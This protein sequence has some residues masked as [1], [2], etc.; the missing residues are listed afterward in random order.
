MS[1]SAR[2]LSRLGSLILIC[3]ALPAH[4]AQR[5]LVTLIDA[6]FAHTGERYVEQLQSTLTPAVREGTRFDV[7]VTPSKA[8]RILLGTG[9]WDLAIVSTDAL[10]EMSVPTDVLAFRIP[11]LF[12][13]MRAVLAFQTS[14]PG[15][16][17]LGDPLQRNLLGLT[18][19]NAGTDHLISRTPIRSPQ[20]LAGRKIAVAGTASADTIASL[21]ATPL[22][23]PSSAFK[24]VLGRSEVDAVA[25]S[26][27]LPSGS[28]PLSKGGFLLRNAVAAHVALVAINRARWYEVPFSVRARIDDAAITAAKRIDSAVREQEDALFARAKESGLWMGGFKDEDA[29][30]A[31]QD[32]IERQPE[33]LRKV[34]AAAYAQVRTET[35][36]R[37]NAR[38]TSA[39]SP[40]A[41]ESAT[42]YF[43]TTRDD[44]GD[45]DLAYRFGDGRT[46]VVK[47]GTVRAAPQGDPQLVGPATADSAACR[48]WLDSIVSRNP[49]T[50][51]FVHG[52]NNRFS[53]AMARGFVLKRALGADTAVI[54]W[55]WPS[56]HEGLL[57][58]YWYDKESIGGAAALGLHQLLKALKSGSEHADLDLLAHS[59]GAWHLLNVLGPLADDDGRPKID[60]VVFAAPDVPRDEFRFALA[61]LHNMGVHPTLY[62][63]ARDRALAVSAGLQSYPRAGTGG[64][65]IVIDRTLDSV[66][67]DGRLIS[68]NHAY[69]FETPEVLRDVATLIDTGRNPAARGLEEEPKTPWHYWRFP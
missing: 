2:F 21:G 51:I 28:V 24:S 61:P 19:L 58:D 23:M 22:T 39:P 49:R 15:R 3:I 18:Y 38:R 30:R 13:D 54:V 65:Q 8:L 35:E 31:A 5:T 57:G 60:G 67:V 32:W 40:G 69:V 27:A 4:S 47:C 1:H 66:D 16:L 43:A 64:G 9:K 53:E 68:L 34:Y 12:P 6:S 17:G 29:R 55:S 46:D 63:C 56:K 59:M 50:L 25:A 33:R 36:A 45:P 37:R 11:Y 7:R 20:E 10:A 14:V 26:G 48:K 52:F 42:I 41:G 44:T 62:A